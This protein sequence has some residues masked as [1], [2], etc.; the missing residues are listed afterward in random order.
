M[1]IASARNV[2]NVLFFVILFILPT[3]PRFSVSKDS[4]AHLEA[5][6]G[7]GGRKQKS[8]PSQGFGNKQKTLEK[9][10]LGRLRKRGVSREISGQISR[11]VSGEGP[12]RPHGQK[13]A[14]KHWKNVSS[15]AQQNRV[16][17]EVSGEI[18]REVSASLRGG[19]RG[20]LWEN[21]LGCLWGGRWRTAPKK[22]KS[23]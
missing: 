19:L 4:R 2:A 16:C 22:Q 21:L 15:G 7:L 5:R 13:I 20:G 9:C 3:P 12:G 1:R 18:S 6:P 10:T 11:D 14:R 23:V 17:R 8:I